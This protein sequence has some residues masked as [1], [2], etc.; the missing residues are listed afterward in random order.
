MCVRVCIPL[1]FC[2]F[3]LLQVKIMKYLYGKISKVDLG[4]SPTSGLAFSV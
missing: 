1:M 2:K 4:N 3:S